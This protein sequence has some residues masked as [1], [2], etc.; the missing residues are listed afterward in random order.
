MATSSCD[1]PDKVEFNVVRLWI[2]HESPRAPWIIIPLKNIPPPGSCDDRGVLGSFLTANT[3]NVHGIE[4]LASRLML[5]WFIL[6]FLPGTDSPPPKDTLPLINGGGF[7]RVGKP[8][9]NNV[10]LSVHLLP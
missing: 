8:C 9:P 6:T 10:L 3:A 4:E 5:L 2:G 7:V 1:R